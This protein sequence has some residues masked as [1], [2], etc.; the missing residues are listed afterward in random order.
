MMSYGWKERRGR[1]YEGHD[2]TGLDYD[3]STSA[4]DAHGGASIRA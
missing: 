4:T 1:N 2:R 3:S